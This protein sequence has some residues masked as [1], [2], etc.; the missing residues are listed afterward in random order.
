MSNV[1]RTRLTVWF[2]TSS[3]ID[4]PRQGA[5]QPG[6]SFPDV[7]PEKQNHGAKSADMDRD[8]YHLALILKAREAGQKYQVTG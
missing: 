8:V 3:R 2:T 6:Q 1:S 7:G 5:R 4:P